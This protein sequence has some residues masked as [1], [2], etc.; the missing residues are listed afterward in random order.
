MVYDDDAGR[1][2]EVLARVRERAGELRL[3]LH[4]EKTRL[5]RTSDPVAFLGFVLQRR[6]DGVQMRL[7]QDN[8]RRMRQRVR[9]MKVEYAAGGMLPEEVTAR[10]GAWLAHARHGHT[11]ALV[12]REQRAWVFRRGEV[13]EER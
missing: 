11:R 2:R 9:A 6:G 4:P 13:V 12:E 7:R 8:V 1:L 10:L 3:R 5:Y